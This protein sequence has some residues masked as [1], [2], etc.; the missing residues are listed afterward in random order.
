MSQLQ[1]NESYSVHVDEMDRQHMR[2]FD[3]INQLSDAMSK[4]HGREV[5]GKTI[6]ALLSYTKTHFTAEEKLLTQC[7]YAELKAQQAMH[8]TFVDKVTEFKTQCDSGRLTLSVAVISF[9]TDWLKKHIRQEDA[10]YG[11]VLATAGIK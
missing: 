5:L 8:K 4:G 2:L 7:H 1:W 3:L 10:K 11:S 9:L 6:E